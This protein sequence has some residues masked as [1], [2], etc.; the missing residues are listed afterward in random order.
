MPTLA[1]ESA[2]LVQTSVLEE[3][4]AVLCGDVQGCSVPPVPQTE[5]DLRRGTQYLHTTLGGGKQLVVMCYPELEVRDSYSREGKERMM[6]S[7]LVNMM[8]SSSLNTMS[9]CTLGRGCLECD[10]YNLPSST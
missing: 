5:V 8:T 10:S 2:V 7:F 1:V 9:L 6:T 3:L 4:L